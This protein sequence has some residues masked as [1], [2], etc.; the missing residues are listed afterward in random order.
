MRESFV[1][2]CK[3]FACSVRYRAA[4]IPVI[5]NDRI[6]SA[7]AE[8]GYRRAPTNFTPEQI[9]RQASAQ[10]SSCG[11]AFVYIPRSTIVDRNGNDV[12]YG[13]NDDLHEKYRQS[14]RRA[15]ARIYGAT[16]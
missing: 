10:V 12:V 9:S 7:M 1:T 6:L 15:A 14:V 2:L 16:P 13:E 8:D 11:H 3:E 4:L 5:P